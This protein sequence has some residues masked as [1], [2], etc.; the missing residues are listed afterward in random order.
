MLTA[1]SGTVTAPISKPMGAR[2]RSNSSSVA[3][4]VSRNVLADEG[5]LAPAADHAQ[6]GQRPMDA[7]GQ[8]LRIVPVAAGHQ[9]DETVRV[10]RAGGDL[11]RD[12]TALDPNVG[13]EVRG[14]GKLGP[15]VDQRHVEADPGRPPARPPGR[16]ARRRQSPAAAAAGPARRRPLRPPSLSVIPRRTAAAGRFPGTIES[17]RRRESLLRGR[18]RMSQPAIG[19]STSTSFP[20]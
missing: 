2:T 12:G 7:L 13:R 10:Q 11:F 18:K 17:R 4:P 3:R 19:S 14:V 20:A 16:R 5:H 6:I 1:I 15:I 8:R 9:D